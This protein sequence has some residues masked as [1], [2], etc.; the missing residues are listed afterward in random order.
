MGRAGSE[1]PWQQQ[2]RRV[3]SK[4]VD[5]H[6][7]SFPDLVV[8]APLEARFQDGLTL[9]R[10]LEALSIRV[11]LRTPRQRAPKGRA[12][13]ADNI[14]R[15][16]AL[17][18][19]EG[20]QLVSIGTNE[21][22][23]GQTKLVLALVW[24][25]IK[26]YNLRHLQRR[27]CVASSASSQAT[28]V[29]ES[30]RIGQAKTS[31]G[32]VQVHDSDRATL[33]AW[34][35]TAVQPATLV[36]NFTSDWTS[37]VMFHALESHLN[38]AKGLPPPN[39]TATMEELFQEAL[40]YHEIPRLLSEGDLVDPE[41]LSTMLYVSCFRKAHTEHH[42]APV[43]TPCVLYVH[44]VTVPGQCLLALPHKGELT[45]PRGLPLSLGGLTHTAWGLAWTC[46]PPCPWYPEPSTLLSN[47]YGRDPHNTWEPH[48]WRLAGSVPPGVTEVLF[49]PVLVWEHDMS[50]I[51]IGPVLCAKAGQIGMVKFSGGRTS[52]APL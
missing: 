19:E 16:L 20:I 1:A 33:L 11:L 52:Y 39:P 18:Q 34:V 28:G 10:L 35:N 48:C 6:L 25:L 22:L 40:Q 5:A 14:T 13:C 23:G 26:H 43:E 8:E 50:L 27:A 29:P 31:E 47:G 21:V 4:W 12:A 41:E 3:F 17:M 51:D 15:A 46:P 2:Q 24:T 45:G 44:R 9:P 7:T 36:S 38:R 49:R 42:E 32:A 37:G 30:G